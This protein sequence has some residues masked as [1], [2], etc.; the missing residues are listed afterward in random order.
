MPQLARCVSTVVLQHLHPDTRRAPTNR[1]PVEG[2]MLD[3]PGARWSSAKL[4]KC[5]GWR[6]QRGDGARLMKQPRL[7]KYS[8]RPK[9]S[10]Q[11]TLSTIIAMQGH[12]RP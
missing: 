8:S 4:E 9:H 1:A 11:A 7:S 12:H 3:V 6:S 2:T 5:R 10:F